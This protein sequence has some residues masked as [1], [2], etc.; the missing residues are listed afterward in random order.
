MKTVYSKLLLFVLSFSYCILTLILFL[1][2]GR[3]LLPR[4]QLID[5]YGPQDED[6]NEN[7]EENEDENFSIPN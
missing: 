6:E 2:P 4:F 3:P 7:D 5:N 1:C